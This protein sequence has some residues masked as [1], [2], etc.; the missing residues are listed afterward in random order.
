LTH[1]EPP[2]S[3]RL[4]VRPTSVAW[5][6]VHPARHDPLHFGT[7]PHNRFDAPAGEF[8][9]LYVAA[10]AHGAFI[11]TFGHATGVRFVTTAELRA[12]GLAVITARRALRLVDLRGEGLARMGADAQ[13]TSGSDLSL[14]RRWARAI[15]DHR[16]RP[17]GILYRARHDPA[18]TCAAIFDRA[19]AVLTAR[20]LGPLSTKEH[21]GLLADILDTYAFG[22]VR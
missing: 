5:Y 15:H 2:A 22:L 11:E 19:A 1:P 20:R 14:S 9:V 10:D 21:E 16:R 4:L 17:D 13:L 7:V 12:R 6:R 18:R 3:F 8:G